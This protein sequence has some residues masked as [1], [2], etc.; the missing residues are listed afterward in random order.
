MWKEKNFLFGFY[1]QSKKVTVVQARSHGL[2][3]NN[4]LCKIIEIILN[5][6]TIRG[7]LLD[8]AKWRLLIYNSGS[9]L[10]LKL[11]AAFNFIMQNGNQFMR[12]INNLFSSHFH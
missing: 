6:V 10:T 11:T 12:T 2:P 8:F 9:W 4:L 3:W 7:A 1:T 5:M